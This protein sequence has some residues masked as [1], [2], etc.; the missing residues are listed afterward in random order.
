MDDLPVLSGVTAN[1]PP[2]RLDGISINHM[3]VTLSFNAG[4]DSAIPERNSSFVGRKYLLDRLQ[5]EI[6]AGRRGSATREVHIVLY[7]TGGMGKTQLALEYVYSHSQ[8]YSAVFWVNATSIETTTLGFVS[9]MQSLIDYHSKI[10]SRLDYPRI[11]QILGMTGKVDERG[12]IISGEDKERDQI[13]DAVKDYFTTTGNSNWLLVLDNADDDSF[14]DQYIPSCNGA[15]ILTSRRREMISR[16][17]GFEIQQMEHSEAEMLLYTTANR[18]L[19]DLNL[20][21]AG[22]YA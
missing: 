8:D 10:A 2:M 16:R 7:G 15:V 13:V 6:Q 20:E 17:R 21:P 22:E 4:R 14:I 1:Y 11:A 9:I 19:S 12:R 5:K 18:R 3:Q